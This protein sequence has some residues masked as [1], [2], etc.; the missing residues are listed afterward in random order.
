MLG[1]GRHARGSVARRRAV[2]VVPTAEIPRPGPSGVKSTFT[3][4]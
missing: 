4:A 1:Y 3:R 2:H